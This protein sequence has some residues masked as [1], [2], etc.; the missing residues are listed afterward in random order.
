MAVKVFIL[1]RPGSG[2]T[3][4]AHYI[5]SIVRK[6]GY[7][8]VATND[9]DVLRQKFLNDIN[10][11]KFRATA[12]NGFDVL[13]FSVL[14]TALQE[15]EQK[16]QKYMTSV[17]LVTIEFARDNYHE[18]FKQFSPGFL[19]DAYFLYIHADTETCLERIHWRVDHP[20]SADDH[21]SL[22][23]DAFRLYYGKE[24]LPYMAHNFSRAYGIND[25]MLKIIGNPSTSTWRS[26]IEKIDEVARFIHEREA[27]LL[28]E[29][30]TLKVCPTPTEPDS[31]QTV[32]SLIPVGVG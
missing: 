26:F 15:L 10:H 25:T 3:T 21:P 8:A 6:N 29:V 5:T 4:A 1:G 24:N 28:R 12:N 16:V 20:H 31:L 14:D 19:R 17:D 13:D 32:S 7:S 9:Y 22:S 27:L 30:S 18:A 23:D 11:Y 2:K